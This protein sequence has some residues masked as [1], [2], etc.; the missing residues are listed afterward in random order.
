M[1]LDFNVT[2]LITAKASEI[3]TYTPMQLKESILKSEGRVIMGQT[4]LKNPFLIPGCTSTEL[5]FA[6]GGDMVMLNGFDF[7]NP[8]KANGMQGLTLKE[9]RAKVAQKPVGI[10]MGCPKENDNELDS[11]PKKAEMKS[12]LYS[13]EN[14]R[15]AK[16]MGA[17]FIVLGGNPGSGTSIKD[18]IRAT[19]EARE[20]LG[21]DMLIFAGKWEDGI[22]EK[23]L[24]DPLADYNAKEVIMELIDAGA[25][26]IDLPAPGSRHG[27]T[28]EMIRELTEFTHR[29]RPDTLVM[30]FLDSNVEIADQDTIRQIAILMKQTG[31]DIHAIGDGGF[32]GGT[33]PENIYQMAI[34]MKGKAYTWQKMATPFR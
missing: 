18:V 13:K 24:G 30:C 3:A 9:L 29:Y 31:A 11:D 12:M 4:Y 25:D 16:E 17:S 2:R 23:V 6:F 20:I 21:D 34:T 28:V 1:Q 5:M 26:V 10:Y 32:G 15:K 7:N 27:I 22:T 19:K 8:E 33:W 14:A